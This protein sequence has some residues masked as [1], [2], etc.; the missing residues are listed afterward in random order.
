MI[1][2]YTLDLDSILV[3]STIGGQTL[4]DGR[5]SIWKQHFVRITS[6][7]DWLSIFTC[8]LKP[9]RNNAVYLYI[10]LLLLLLVRTCR[11]VRIL[12]NIDQILTKNTQTNKNSFLLQKGMYKKNAP[13]AL[14]SVADMGWGYQY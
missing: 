5:S 7:P 11:Y 13:A 1:C 10:L 14:V 4:V 8:S 9:T 6:E 2:V 3:L 12:T